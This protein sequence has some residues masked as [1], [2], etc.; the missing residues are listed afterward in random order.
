MQSVMAHTRWKLGQLADGILDGC[1]EVRPYRLGT[2]SPC[3]WCPMTSVCRF[4]MGLCDVRFYA[5][6]SRS[7]VFDAIAAGRDSAT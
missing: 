5:S 3:S 2:L 1:V 4:E 6:L 7:D